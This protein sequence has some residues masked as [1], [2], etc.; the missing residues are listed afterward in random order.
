[1]T[2]EPFCRIEAFDPSDIP[3]DE[4]PGSPEKERVTDQRCRTCGRWFSVNGIQGHLDNRWL[5]PLC[6]EFDDERGLVCRKV[7][8]FCEIIL[9]WDEP[10]DEQDDSHKSSCPVHSESPLDPEDAA[11][12]L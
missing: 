7:C 2:V 3:A 4:I 1:V 10:A 9:R 6:H 11:E 12:F 5:N 8:I